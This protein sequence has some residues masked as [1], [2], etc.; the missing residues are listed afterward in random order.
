MIRI[1]KLGLEKSTSLSQLE[2]DIVKAMLDAA[3][4]LKPQESVAW[5]VSKWFPF[6]NA[7]LIVR[8]D[9]F[10]GESPHI[11]DRWDRARIYTT[12]FDGNHHIIN[13]LKVKMRR[14][15]DGEP[16]FVFIS[17]GNWRNTDCLGLA[18]RMMLDA[19]IAPDEG[20]NEVLHAFYG[21]NG[22]VNR[23]S[24]KHLLAA[25]AALKRSPGLNTFFS[26][27]LTAALL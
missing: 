8:V 20:S 1:K 9:L 19:G 14:S 12:L 15:L 24:K 13:E 4:R 18:V 21:V 23:A 3:A 11:A 16:E 17:Q 22:F 2:A 6:G 26:K 7:L 25:G 10:N 27:D 5:K